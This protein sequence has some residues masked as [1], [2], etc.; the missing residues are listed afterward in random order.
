MDK[1]EEQVAAKTMKR[2]TS[3]ALEYDR[4]YESLVSSNAGKRVLEM[5]PTLRRGIREKDDQIEKLQR[6]LHQCKKEKNE[7]EAEMRALKKI[8]GSMELCFNRNTSGSTTRLAQSDATVA[9]NISRSDTL[10]LGSLVEAY[11][12]LLLE[13]TEGVREAVQKMQQVK[14]ELLNITAENEQLR[15]TANQIRTEARK[16]DELTREKESLVAKVQRFQQFEQQALDLQQQLQREQQRL[17]LRDDV[18]RKQED[19][20]KE[21]KQKLRTAENQLSLYYSPEQHH[22]SVDLCKQELAECRGRLVQQQQQAAETLNSMEEQA[23][24]LNRAEQAITELESSLRDKEKLLRRST[25]KLRKREAFV[26][27][28]GR[29]LRRLKLLCRYREQKKSSSVSVSVLLL[30]EDR[31]LD[32]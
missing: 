3:I 13:K 21:L 8:L 10:K 5:E 6:L 9:F 28:M 23:L 18:L 25:K 31:A 19:E 12:E 30:S 26:T 17:I 15:Q 14:E 27:D 1:K 24:N 22:A 4:L 16:I 11:D 20:A 29:K 2:L 7:T 32:F